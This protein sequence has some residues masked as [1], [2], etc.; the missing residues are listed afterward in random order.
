MGSCLRLIVLFALAEDTDV[1]LSLPWN[2]EC[3]LDGLLQLNESSEYTMDHTRHHSN[4]LRYSTSTPQRWCA[5]DTSIRRL[6]LMFAPHRWL[7]TNEDRVG[8]SL[9]HP[10]STFCPDQ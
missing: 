10:T 9:H 8:V 2:E 1:P 6:C 3:S 7:R 5:D 4:P